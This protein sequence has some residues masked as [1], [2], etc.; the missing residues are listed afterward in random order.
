MAGLQGMFRLEGLAGSGPHQTFCLP[1]ESLLQKREWSEE[2]AT[3]HALWTGEVHGAG[4]V[5]GAGAVCSVSVSC[6]ERCLPHTGVETS[7]D[8]GLQPPISRVLGDHLFISWGWKGITAAFVL[9]HGLRRNSMF[10]NSIFPVLFIKKNKCVH[11][12]PPRIAWLQNVPSAWG[13][14][15]TF[16]WTPPLKS[17]IFLFSQ[18]SAIDAAF[19]S[20]TLPTHKM[21]NKIRRVFHHVRA[22]VSIYFISKWRLPTHCK[23]GVHAAAL[24]S[25]LPNED[26]RLNGK[27]NSSPLQCGVPCLAPLELHRQ[28]GSR[29]FLQEPPSVKGALGADRGKPSHDTG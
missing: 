22:D 2:G 4:E 27:C 1:L 23:G 5:Q 12:K 15:V 11:R 28:P 9:W 14:L 13:N 3:G 6:A 19:C 25:S 17:F 21:A 18:K 10:W 7:K 16:A 29:L 24:A 20:V 8:P 26:S